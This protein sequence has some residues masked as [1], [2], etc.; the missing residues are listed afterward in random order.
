MLSRRHEILIGLGVVAFAAIV[1]W[2]LIPAYVTLPRRPPLRALAP[3]FFPKIIGWTML[4]TG[5]GL[6]LKA[7]LAP[8]TPAAIAVTPNIDRGELL[9]I[10]GLALILLA[11]YLALPVFGMV[12][13]SMVV[14][15]LL[16]LLTGRRRLGWGIVSAVLLPLLLY[17][18]F[19]KVAGVAIPQGQ[20]VRL[21]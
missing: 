10:G 5:A 11:S 14:F 21:P 2:W 15:L 19:A 9:R 4:I 7:V 1:L 20:I 18:F 17:L 12:W 6:A 3:S 16:V 8:P 13:T